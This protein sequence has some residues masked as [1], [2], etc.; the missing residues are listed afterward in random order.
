MTDELRYGIIKYNKKENNFIIVCSNR[1]IISDSRVGFIDLK[2]LSLKDE[3]ERED[4]NKLIAYMKPLMINATD[5]NVINQDNNIF[6]FNKLLKIN[7][8]KIQNDVLP[9][10]M[11]M[12]KGIKSLSTIVGNISSGLFIFSYIYPDIISRNDGSVAMGAS[13]MLSRV[14]TLVNVG[15][16]EEFDNDLRTDSVCGYPTDEVLGKQ[17]SMEKHEQSSLENHEQSSFTDLRKAI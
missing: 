13:R 5:R 3:L 11:I 4:I 1:T 7:N 17:S 9:K 8:I 6:Y 10:E 15:S 12:G 2:A 16:G 14:N